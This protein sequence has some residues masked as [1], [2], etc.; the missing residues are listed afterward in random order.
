MQSPFTRGRPY[1]WD[2][3]RHRPGDIPREWGIYRFIQSDK[4]VDYIG[5]TSNLYNRISDHRSKATYYNSGMHVVN[6]QLARIG[7]T[8]DE[9]RQW[10]VFKIQQRNPGLVTYIGGNGRRPAIEVNGE[11][12]EM[13]DGESV[14]EAFQRHMIRG[15][16]Y[17]ISLLRR[18]V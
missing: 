6:Y 18:E 9:M 8:W 7:T 15:R 17:F 14:Q 5:I 10:E 1:L 2:E 12:V 3:S 11:I 16:D 4:T 13:C